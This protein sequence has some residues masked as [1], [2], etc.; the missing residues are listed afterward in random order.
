MQEDKEDYSAQHRSF[1]AL[2]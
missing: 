2:H 1:A